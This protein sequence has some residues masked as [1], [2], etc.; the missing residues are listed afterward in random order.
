MPT[1]KIIAAIDQQLALLQQARSLLI[2][3]AAPGLTAK[4]RG[5]PKTVEVVPA[6]N[7]PKH[8]M[9]AEG[10]ARIAAAQK[11][12]WAALKKSAAPAESAAKKS[13]RKPK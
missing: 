8:T 5:R 4:R 2:E 1:E 13:P 7:A 6:P 3:A 9:S 11:A 12:R 10:K